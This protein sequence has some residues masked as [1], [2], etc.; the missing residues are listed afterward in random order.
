MG[1]A[2]GLLG[3]VSEHVDEQGWDFVRIGHGSVLSVR[4]R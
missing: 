3:A 4:V 2:P 1:H